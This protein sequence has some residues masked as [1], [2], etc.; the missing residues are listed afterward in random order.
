[1]ERASMSAR[2]RLSAL[3]DAAQACRNLTLVLAAAL[4]LAD[5]FLPALG[6]W[7]LVTVVDFIAIQC[8]C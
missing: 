6:L 3:Q 5:T 7:F 1:M 2:K 8:R 4:T